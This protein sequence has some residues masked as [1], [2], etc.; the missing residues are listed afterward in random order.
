MSWRHP[1]DLV[2]LLE[3]VLARLPE[4][5]AAAGSDPDWQPTDD[6]IATLLGDDPAAIVASLTAALADGRAGGTGQPGSV[7]YA[8]AL[9]VARFHTSNEFGDWITV[10]HT[11]TPRQ[12]RAPVDAAGAFAGAAARASTTARCASTSIAS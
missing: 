3:P 9:R 6:L 12:R 4:L 8:A 2:A 10:L 5:F 11:F 1:V 7:S